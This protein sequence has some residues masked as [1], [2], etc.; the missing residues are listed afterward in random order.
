MYCTAPVRYRASRSSEMLLSAAMPLPANSCVL[1]G[2]ERARGGARFAARA[3]PYRDGGPWLE[4][5]LFV[6]AGETR[7]GRESGIHREVAP[8]R[9]VVEGGVLSEAKG[10]LLRGGSRFW[11]VGTGDASETKRLGPR[12]GIVVSAVQDQA[13]R[14]PQLSVPSRAQHRRQIFKVFFPCPS[15]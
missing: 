6:R 13:G 15:R 11:G 8:N 14:L 3:G 7:R 4:S 1:C 9:H 12:L 2:R 5:A 10:V